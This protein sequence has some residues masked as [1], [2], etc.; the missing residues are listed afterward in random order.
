MAVIESLDSYRP[1]GDSDPT[2]VSP[3][4]SPPSIPQ[5]SKEIEARPFHYTHDLI[6]QVL[7]ELI[8]EGDVPDRRQD[9][10]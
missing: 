4:P 10:A 5:R 3:V 6:A 7:P 9:A 2:D 8:E 1:E